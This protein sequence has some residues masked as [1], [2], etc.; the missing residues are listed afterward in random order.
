MSMILPVNNVFSDTI[1]HEGKQFYIIIACARKNDYYFHPQKLTRKACTAIIE[2]IQ[3]RGYIES[4]H[5]VK[6]SSREIMFPEYWKKEKSSTAKNITTNY[7]ADI[8]NTE[9]RYQTLEEI[10][11]EKYREF[12]KYEIEKEL[13]AQRQKY[14]RARDKQDEPPK[15]KSRFGWLTG[16]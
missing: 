13:F 6:T 2:R 16:K 12:Q 10:L 11:H 8:D 9:V 15:K 1:S 4:K 3:S 7:T 5:W 14:K